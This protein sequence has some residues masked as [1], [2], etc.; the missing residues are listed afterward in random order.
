MKLELTKID[1]YTCTLEELEEEIKRLDD[2]MGENYNLE[3]SIKIFINSIYGALAS[4]FF[5][6]YNIYAAEGVTLQGQH[7]IHYTNKI[8]DDYFLN[9]WHLDKELHKKMQLRFM[10]NKI[11][12]KS[13]IVYNDTDSTYMTFKPVLD[14]CR[15]KGDPVEFI[16]NLKKYRLDS[17]LAQKFGEYAKH[18][19]TRDLQNLEMETV[20]YAALMMQKKKYILNIAWKDP[21]VTYEKGTKIKPVGIELVQSST[22]KF[23]RE[24][25]KQMIELIFDKE[26]SLSYSDV[27]S[28]LRAHKEKF[29]MQDPNEISLTMSIG[30]YDKFVIEDKNRVM[31]EKGCPINVRAAAIYNNALMNSK[32]KTKYNLLKTGDKV[33]FYY[34][35]GHHNVFGFVPGNYPMEFA[36]PMDFDAQFE[37]TV[38]EP[39]NRYLSAIGFNPIPGHLVYAK[40][41][42]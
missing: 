21:G 6:G 30:D 34:S 11:K 31:V 42:F 32:F 20:S 26:K 19:N 5:V 25:L 16:L 41:L 9:M 33:K 18:F 15:W 7:I 39:L 35:K 37:R 3:Q 2:V 40:P 10:A 38:V 14:S 29:K 17:Y 13:L 27:V 8:L 1:P 36:N 28:K 24:V 22:P 23:C 12:A 4:P